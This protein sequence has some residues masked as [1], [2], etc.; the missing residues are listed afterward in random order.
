MEVVS[1]GTTPLGEQQA[2]VA[3]LVERQP[4]VVNVSEQPRSRQAP[5]RMGYQVPSRELV[6]VVRPGGTF[7]GTVTQFVALVFATFTIG[8]P[9]TL[10]VLQD[11]ILH[12]ID[13][14]PVR[15]EEIETPWTQRVTLR[16]QDGAWRVHPPRQ[17]TLAPGRTTVSCQSALP[18]LPALTFAKASAQA[19]TWKRYAVRY[20]AGLTAFPVW[21]P[22]AAPASA[23]FVN[24]LAVPFSEVGSDVVCRVDAAPGVPTIVDVVT[25]TPLPL[26]A[27]LDTQLDL[28]RST[29]AVWRYRA[30]D[31]GELSQG[32]LA[33]SGEWALSRSLAVPQS[34]DYQFGAIPLPPLELS[35]LDGVMLAARNNDLFGLAGLVGVPLQD[36]ADSLVVTVST[37]IVRVKATAAVRSYT[38]NTDTVVTIGLGGA[39]I[40]TRD[41]ES[42]F[43]RRVA[44]EGYAPGVPEWGAN[45]P[46]RPSYA[47]VGNQSFPFDLTFTEPVAAVALGLEPGPPRAQEIATLPTTGGEKTVTFRYA[48]CVVTA[49]PLDAIELTVVTPSVDLVASGTVRSWHVQVH[50][51]TTQ[52]SV[53]LWAITGDGDLTLDLAHGVFAGADPVIPLQVA[54]TPPDVGI[55]LVPGENA[56]TCSHPVTLTWE[57]R[58]LL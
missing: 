52:E 22:G 57:D 15:V 32:A 34:R 25:A 53:E 55:R 9:Q 42:P 37:G 33:G 47:I 26:N 44:A 13:A 36:D 51:E 2:L 41:P 49:W 38:W 4:F 56:L 31:A 12:V 54:I 8:T 21:L 3:W 58:S 5:S 17:I 30:L 10:A 48:T 43:W 18:V 50:N 14:E 46:G 27:P 6:L 1:F 45:D 20:A 29:P 19:G 11:G 40:R 23:V 35:L 24:G 39:A 7:A 28:A 16:A